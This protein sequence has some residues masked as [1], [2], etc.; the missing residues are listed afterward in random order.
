MLVND[1]KQAIEHFGKHLRKKE[2][3]LKITLMTNAYG[4]KLIET[5]LNNRYYILF[6]R[7]HFTSFEGGYGESINKESLNYCKSMNV[8]LI[9][10]VYCDGKIYCATPREIKGFGRERLQNGGKETTVS[11]SLKKLKRF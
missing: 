1:S 5:Q 8:H 4:H 2:D 6:K 9:C 11:F 7:E 10:F 3:T